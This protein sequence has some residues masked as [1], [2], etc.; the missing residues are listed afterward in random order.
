LRDLRRD[1]NKAD[2]DV[3]Q[4]LARSAAAK[5]V[6]AA[7]QIIALLDTAT[8]EPTRTQITDVM[9]IYER[10]ILRDVTWHP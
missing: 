7:R 2:Y 4:S 10:D 5:Q 8:A 6:Q 9:K 1:R 3:E